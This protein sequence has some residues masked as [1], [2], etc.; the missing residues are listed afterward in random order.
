MNN[1]PNYFGFNPFPSINQEQT[2]NDNN[3]ENNQLMLNDMLHTYRNLSQTT[4]DVFIGYNTVINQYNQNITRFLS[5]MGDHRNSIN[6]LN[7]QLINSRQSSVFNRNN[8]PNT[9]TN[10]TS[11]RRRTRNTH[12]EPAF[13]LPI[14]RNNFNFANLT[15]TFEDIIVRPTQ[16]QITNATETLAYTDRI[17]LVN[18]RCPIT[19]EDF[20]IGDTISIIRHCGHT[21]HE[22]SINNWFRT[23][24]RCPVCRYDIRDYS[25]TNNIP[26]DIS[27]NN[28]S[29]NTTTE[30]DSGIMD[31]LTN[32][33]TNLFTT[34][35]ENQ[36][37]NS[38]ISQNRIFTVDI[39]ITVTSRTETQEP[40]ILNEYDSEEESE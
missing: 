21:F 15:P 24:V 6:N 23:N 25:N 8:A 35:M 11:T 36:I 34:A 19:M 22:D 1:Y 10:N 18:S 16:E 29:N 2:N 5:S 32:Q 26:S 17:N 14:F 30:L 7:M 20:N 3:Q 13:R 12:R 38:D 40:T 4:R 31:E 9:S 28:I 39:P 27:S 33:I 37:S